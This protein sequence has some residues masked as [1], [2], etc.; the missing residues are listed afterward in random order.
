MKTNGTNIEFTVKDIK[1]I[2]TEFSNWR[3]PKNNPNETIGIV[4]AITTENKKEKLRLQNDVVREFESYLLHPKFKSRFKIIKYSEKLSVQ[5]NSMITAEKFVR[6][7]KCNFILYGSISERNVQGSNTYIF[8]LDALI[9]HKMLSENLKNSLQSDFS[10]TLPTRVEFPEVNETVGFEMTSDILRFAIP[11][12]I[13]CAA[14]STGVYTLA[15]D[16]LNEIRNEIGALPLEKVNNPLITNLSERINSR[17]ENVLI[18]IVSRHYVAFSLN[19]DKKFLFDTEKYLEI[20]NSINP[21]T[22]QG[23][24]CWS[25]LLFLK[26]KIP[27]AIEILESVTNKDDVTWRYNLGFLY[28]YVGNVPKALEQYKKAGYGQVDNSTINDFEIFMT[29]Q[30]KFGCENT[31]LL[32]FFRGFLNFKLRKD[33]E[34]AANDFKHFLSTSASVAN[35]KLRELSEKYLSMIVI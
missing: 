14:H 21:N 6:K 19:R 10:S 30:I 31:E 25:I 9:T 13:A 11:F 27:K 1:D 29:E 12:I 18:E 5:I 15:F 16:I 33:F 28:A 23:K 3:I 32:I 8:K 2:L 24:L 34:L 4:I 20:L 17:L 22:Y 26:G 7:S 35:P